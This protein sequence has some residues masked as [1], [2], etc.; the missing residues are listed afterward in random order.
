M[1]EICR[2]VLAQYV[3]GVTL[4]GTG[5]CKR[6]NVGEQLLKMTKKMKEK[7]LINALYF[8]AFLVLLNS[9]FQEA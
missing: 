7:K 6:L 3:Y 4:H 8:L 2:G 5:Q 1:F 9:C